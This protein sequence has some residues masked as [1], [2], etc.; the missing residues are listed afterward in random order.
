VASLELLS[1]TMSSSRVY[2]C[3]RRLRRQASS[4]AAARRQRLRR[5]DQTAVTPAE[6]IGDHRVELARTAIP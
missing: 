2:V 3:P 1:M 6:K 4:V 5:A